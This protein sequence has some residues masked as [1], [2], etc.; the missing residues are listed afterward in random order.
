MVEGALYRLSLSRGKG[1]KDALKRRHDNAHCADGFSRVSSHQYHS[2]K[3]SIFEQRIIPYGK[4]NP[5]DYKI[6]IPEDSGIVPSFAYFPRLS[7][8]SIIVRP[9]TLPSCV[10]PITPGCSWR[11]WRT[12]FIPVDLS[13]FDNVLMLIFALPCSEIFGRTLRVATGEAFYQLKIFFTKL[14][15]SPEVTHG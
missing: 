10:A 12:R 8:K 13:S 9:T 5:H 11:T 14:C 3:T 1:E 4:Y 7:A 2:R 15:H 6:A